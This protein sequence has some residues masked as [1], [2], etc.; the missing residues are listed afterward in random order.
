MSR[1]KG[2]TLKTM[3]QIRRLVANEL[4]RVAISETMDDTAR[5]K[6]ILDGARILSDLIEKTDI[7]EQLAKQEADV[8][9][10]KKGHVSNVPL[11]LPKDPKES[12]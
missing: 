9:R 11:F 1:V 4:R 7:E 12:K 8:E 2:P 6:L 5:A 3:G 10:L